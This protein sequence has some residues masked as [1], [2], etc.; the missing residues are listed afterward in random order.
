MSD[1]LSYSL[2]N[3]FYLYLDSDTTFVMQL[4][5]Q[6]GYR[7]VNKW[8]PARVV[9]RYQHTIHPFSPLKTVQFITVPLDMI[10]YNVGNAGHVCNVIDEGM[11]LQHK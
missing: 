5:M 3:V 11:K 6:C 8:N 2:D 7:P 4:H 10:L 9:P 1:I